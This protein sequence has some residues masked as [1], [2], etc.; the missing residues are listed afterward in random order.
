MIRLFTSVYPE[1]YVRRRSEVEECL[2]RNLAS[3]A[4]QL[5]GVFLENLEH[6]PAENAKLQTRCIGHRPKYEDFFQ[7]A[8][9]CQATDTDLTIIA[10]SDIYFDNSVQVL[11]AALRP[12][13]C[14]ALSR[15]DVASNSQCVLSDRNDSQDAWVF[16]GSLRSIRGD[17]SVGVPRC[18]NRILY[19]LR[20]AGYVVINP[21]FSIRSFHL[22]AG[23]RQEYAG[24]NL[25][26][27]VDPPYEYLW[28]HNLWSWPRTVLHN[29]LHRRSRVGWRLDHRRLNRSLPVRVAR[30]VVRVVAART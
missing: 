28:P 8:S 25:D 20:R 18:D 13:Q 29:L 19:E 26:H 14:A 12:S 9:E 3:P 5:V 23:Q 2:R 16:R 7:W 10:N 11:A 27:F 4:I 24:K 1:R 15:W 30:K 17:F 21:A 6:A 22:H